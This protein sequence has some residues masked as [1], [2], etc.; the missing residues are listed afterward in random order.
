MIPYFCGMLTILIPL[1]IG[2]WLAQ[3]KPWNALDDE[4]RRRGERRKP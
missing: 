3:P 4:E 1:A 2:V